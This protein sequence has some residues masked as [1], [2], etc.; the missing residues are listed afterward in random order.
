[1]ARQGKSLVFV[2]ENKE[3]LGLVAVA[4]SLK[5]TSVTAIKKL[6]SKGIKTVL[7]SGDNKLCAEYIG[8]QLGVDEVY[9]EVLPTEKSQIVEEIRKKYGSTLMVGDGINDAPALTSADVGCAIGNGSDIAIESADIVLM[10]SDPEDVARAVNLSKYTII[11]IKENLFWAFCYNSILIPVA[12]GV[13][14]P[15]TEILLSPMLAGLAMSLS[16]ICVVTNALRLKLK[17]KKL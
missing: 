3:Y 11:N 1:M 2:A 17:E 14:Y 16:S 4:D 7:L 13:L 10:K 12:A 6:K 9:S 8:S 5:E 15:F